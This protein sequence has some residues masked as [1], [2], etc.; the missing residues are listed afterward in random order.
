MLRAVRHGLRGDRDAAHELAKAQDDAEGASVHA[1]LHRIE[2]DPGN[3]EYRY[4]RQA[5]GASRGAFIRKYDTDGQALWTARYTTSALD[6]IRAMHA[7]ADGTLWIAGNVF[8]S[9]QGRTSLGQQDVFVARIAADDGRVLEGWQFGSSAPDGLADLQVDRDGNVYL[10]GETQG[11]VQT[12]AANAGATDLYILKLSP[13]G[14][15]PLA[16]RQWGTANDESARRLAVDPCG[17]VLAVGS[18][19]QQGRRS[20]VLWYWKP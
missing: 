4:R 16:A 18:T 20:G 12:G 6:S 13:N 2:G 11:N 8:G 9:F 3:A 14:R 10:L 7:M 17:R 15:T 1:W 19:T 5:T